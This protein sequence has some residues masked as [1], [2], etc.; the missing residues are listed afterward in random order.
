M[1]W[2][3]CLCEKVFRCT[4]SGE[5]PRSIINKSAFFHVIGSVIYPCGT[6]ARMIN[7]PTMGHW[8]YK[9]WH[10]KLSENIDNSCNTISHASIIS[11]H[12]REWNLNK[13]A[14]ISQT[15]TSHRNVVML[16]I[17]FVTGCT[18]SF[19]FDDFWCSQWLKLYPN[20]IFCFSE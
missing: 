5:S 1:H 16:M 2:M 8:H 20:D 10:L 11:H 17:F 3:K 4:D 9:C 19:H 14:D 7:G 13:M 15:L 12:L 18:K 6:P